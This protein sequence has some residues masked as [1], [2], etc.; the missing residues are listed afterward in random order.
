LGS[1]RA[2][3]A[4]GGPDD[5]E[6]AEVPKR[7]RGLGG[8]GDREDTRLRLELSCHAPSGSDASS[9]EPTKPSRS[10]EKRAL[11]VLTIDAEIAAEMRLD[12][13]KPLGEGSITLPS[14]Q[15]LS[16]SQTGAR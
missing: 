3:R 13:R 11:L 7:L 15:V 6:H 8:D 2:A 4:P 10:K 9:I 16:P 12:P 14:L 1:P 5:D